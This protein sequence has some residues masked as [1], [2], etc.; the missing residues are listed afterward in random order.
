MKLDK[1]KITATL[2]ADKDRVVICKHEI[3]T[4]KVKDQSSRV[5]CI[6]CNKRFEI[7]IIDG[8]KSCENCTYTEHLFSKE[9]HQPC[10]KCKKNK[11]LSLKETLKLT[12]DHWISSEEYMKKVG[13]L[14]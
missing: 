2:Y 10:S 8:R 7:T 4:L 3:V 6:K 1:K 13:I 5:D 14:S 9:Y 11:T 12:E